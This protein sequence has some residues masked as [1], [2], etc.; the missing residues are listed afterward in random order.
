MSEQSPESGG[1]D[2]DGPMSVPDDQLPDD[3]RPSEDNPLAEPVDDEVP[4]DVIADTE[5]RSGDGDDETD[6]DDD[7]A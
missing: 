4:D 7:T 5:P 2:D 6:G 3:V 1:R